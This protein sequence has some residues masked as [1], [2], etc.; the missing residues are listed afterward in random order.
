LAQSCHSLQSSFVGRNGWNDAAGINCGADLR[1]GEFLAH[2]FL[3]SSA[4]N[5]PTKTRPPRRSKVAIPDMPPS[6]HAGAREQA[7]N[8]RDR[9][10]IHSASLAFVIVPLS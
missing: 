4:L 9:Q 7:S 5:N 8:L 2:E 10:K 3:D 1:I 6:P